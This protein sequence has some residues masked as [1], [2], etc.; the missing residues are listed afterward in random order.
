MIEIISTIGFLCC[1]ITGVAISWNLIY[2]YTKLST[3]ELLS[4]LV[5][6]E[7]VLLYYTVI[8]PLLLISNGDTSYGYKDMSPYISLSWCGC[9]VFYISLMAGY[10]VTIYP[11]FSRIFSQDTY[12][13]INLRKVFN[14]GILLVVSG[15]ILYMINGGYSLR[16]LVFGGIS[17]SL[18][19]AN[20][21]MSG[22][23][24]QMINFCIP[25]CGLMLIAFLKGEKNTYSMI[26]LIIAV[27]LSFSSFIIAGFRYRIIYLLV[28]FFSIYYIHK[29]KR[30]NVALWAGAFVFL[31]LLMGIIGAT[32][33]YQKGLD[34]S[35]LKGQTNGELMQK[36]MNDTRIFYATGAL[37]N[38]VSSNSNYTYLTPIYTAVCMPIPRSVF[39]EKPDATYLVDMNKRI[40]GTADYGIAF[41]CYGEAFYAFGWLGIVLC[42]LFLGIFSRYVYSMYQTNEKSVSAL[43]LLATY[44]GFTYVVLSRGY[45]AQQVT[46]FFL[47]IAIPIILYKG[48]MRFGLFN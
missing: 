10:R 3:D 43:L 1:C 38:D 2:G 9:F 40:W 6:I 22:Y 21:S 44:N 41:M 7:L 5:F 4:P 46:I 13:E 39:K 17:E 37:M 29:Q 14:I 30:P 28:T 31:I 33:N 15:L 32:R 34:T 45:F 8:S 18:E 35:R 47:V 19:L 23:G 12:E 24:K 48:L 36:G 26:L 42:G 27:F 11:Y 20:G 16:Q 25:G